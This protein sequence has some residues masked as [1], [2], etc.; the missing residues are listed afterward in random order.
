MILYYLG[1][2]CFKLKGRETVVI[3]D[4]YDKSVFGKLMPKTKA[5]I[6]TVSHSHHDHCAV[7]RVDGSP[8]IIN[9]PG[10]YEIKGV[11]IMGIAS[12]HGPERGKNTIYIYTIDDLKFC[13]LGDLGE[14]LNDRQ[15]ETLDGIDVLMIPVGGIYTLNAKEAAFVT[16]QLEPK[17][18][19]PMHYKTRNLSF[20]LDPVEKFLEEIGKEEIKPVDKL[21]VT[22]SSLPEEMEVIWLKK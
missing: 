4:P 9:G 12:T 15:R 14:K 7:D 22:P 2:S 11:D 10:E 19:I 1:H 21:V 3:T 17:V 6:V 8:F 18:V 5:D 16:N 13:H 20:N